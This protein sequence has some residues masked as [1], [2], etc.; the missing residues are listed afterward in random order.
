MAVRD[1]GRPGKGRRSERRPCRDRRFA[2]DRSRRVGERLASA[3]ELSDRY[4]DLRDA[5][6]RPVDRSRFGRET[7]GKV[8]GADRGRHALGRRPRYG[9]GPLEGAR[10]HAC[11]SVALFRLRV[12]RREPVAGRRIQLGLRP[13]KLFRPGGFLCDRPVRPRRADPRVQAN[14][15]E[16]APQRDSRGDG[17]GLQPHSPDRGIEFLADR[18]GI[19]LSARGRP[20][21]F[22]TRRAAGTRRLPNGL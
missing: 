14:G 18:T 4:R 8:S 6:P 12:D 15:P 2:R 17:R 13:E 1:A 16:S 9:A 7:Q 11:P 22:P 10:R 19:L 20:G 5:P 3:D 21:L